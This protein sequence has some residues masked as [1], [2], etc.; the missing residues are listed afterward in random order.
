LE[1]DHRHR[2]Y[3][4]GRAE[5]F[6]LYGR[7]R[8]GKTELL[9]AFCQDKPSLFFI[10][11]LSSDSDQLASFSQAVWRFDHP[12]AGEGPAF[13]SWEA[14]FRALPALPGGRPIVVLDEFT[15]LISGNRA[16]PSILQ[17]VWDEALK[18]APL[19]WWT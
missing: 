19:F 10:A 15:Y 2:L 9:R 14:A 3:H 7:R 17:K 8:V 16:I 12:Q 5:L 13:P 6:I 1:L 18:D 11:T 4:S